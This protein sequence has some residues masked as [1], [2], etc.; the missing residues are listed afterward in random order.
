ML[1]LFTESPQRK[2]TI[3]LFKEVSNS[4]SLQTA[5]GFT[6]G[7]ASSATRRT[8]ILSRLPLCKLV[9]RISEQTSAKDGKQHNRDVC[10]ESVVFKH[11]P[12]SITSKKKNLIEFFSAFNNEYI[13]FRRNKLLCRSAIKHL[14]VFE[15]TQRSANKNTIQCE[16]LAIKI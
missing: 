12:N 10:S 4:I 2:S 8:L 5:S 15:V 9:S 7:A 1:H 13:W 3:I 11:V 14:F 6:V 16:P